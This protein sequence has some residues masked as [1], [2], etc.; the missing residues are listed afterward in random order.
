MNN[1]DLDFDQDYIVPIKV[2]GVGG[3]GGNAVNRMVTSGMSSVAEYVSIN[4]D[5]MALKYSQATYK[6]HIGGKRTGAGGKPEEGRLAAEESRDDI[7]AAIGRDT[8]MVFVT[9]G[10][11]GGTGTGGAPIV[12]QIAKEMGILTVGVV[13]KPFEF[14]GKRKMAQADEG[15][16]ELRKNVD[17]LVV[18]PNE[19]LHHITEEKITLFNAFALADDVLRQAVQSIS[20]L[21]NLPG[22]INV[23]FA[24]VTT[25]VKDAGYAHMGVGQAT[26][27]RKAEKA[28]RAAISSPLLETSIDGAKGVLVNFVASQDIGLNE[29]SEAANLISEAAHPDVNY[30]WGVAFDETMNDELKVTVIATNFENENFPGVSLPV[31]TADKAA[32]SAEEKAAAEQPAAQHAQEVAAEEAP[33]ADTKE[34]DIDEDDWTTLL[35]IFK[36]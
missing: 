19:R 14:E 32:A 1:I 31:W 21:I 16:A 9:A 34:N 6:L 10:M 7:A 27:D 20:D 11:G 3:G 36:N 2:I 29:I 15:I 25:I 26:G 22:M 28:A 33:A 18:I 5:P 24:D 4:T 30:I 13:T 12:A 17:A 8:Q 23:D 35:R